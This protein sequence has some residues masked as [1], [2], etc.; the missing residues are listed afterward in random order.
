MWMPRSGCFFC[1]TMF[2]LL[3]CMVFLLISWFTLAR[4]WFFALLVAALWLMALVMAPPIVSVASLGTR[5]AK[6]IQNSSKVLSRMFLPPWVLW[7][8]AMALMKSQVQN[9]WLAILGPSF[10]RRKKVVRLLNFSTRL[11]ALPLAMLVR[12]PQRNSY[13]R[14]K[15]MGQPCCWF[16]PQC[17]VERLWANCGLSKYALN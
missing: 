4:C 3:L 12:F 1:H 10:S 17:F 2:Y 9:P 15:E 8:M 14:S 13:I 5:I 6:G 16:L 7:I 11:L